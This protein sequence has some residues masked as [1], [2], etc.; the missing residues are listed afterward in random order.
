MNFEINQT[1][2]VENPFNRLTGSE[3][4]KS[5]PLIFM[6][7]FILGLSV[8][9]AGKMGLIATFGLIAVPFVFAYLFLLFKNP[10]IGLYTAFAFGFVLIGLGRYVQGV[11]VGL[12]MD[13]ILFLTLLAFV[14]KNF[15]A[16]NKWQPVKKD[17][18]VLALI[19]FAYYLFEAVNPEAR[20][21]NAWFTGRTVALYMF[22]TIPL[23]LLLIDNKRK[24][25]N[26]FLIWGIFSLLATSKGIMQHFFG[27]D[28][29]ERIWLSEPGNFTTHVLF[30]KLRVFSFL[31]DAGQFGANQGYSAVVA[32][33]YATSQKKFGKKLFFFLVAGMGIYGMMISGT[34]GAISVPAVGFMV[35]IILKKNISVLIPG[36]IIL[37]GLFV[38]FKYT[39]IGQGNAQIARMR[40]AFDPNNASLQVRLENQKKLKAYLATRPFGGGVG[41]AGGKARKFLPNAFLSN[42]PTDSWYVMIWAEMGIVGLVIHLAILFYVVI[43][44]SFMVMFRL[45]DPQLRIQM[46]ALTSGMLGIMAA[47]YG[48]GVLGQMPTGIYIYTSMALMLNAKVF[49]TKKEELNTVTNIETVK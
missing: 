6:L 18:S 47:A 19:W 1:G 23:V 26:F 3:R 46:A 45:R 48:N 42:V 16:K 30:G 17:V 36:F 12:G 28:P 21:I 40:S 11:Q 20:S 33:I 2:T 41:H 4:I 39:Y 15:Y 10:V 43:K 44:S 29:W 13:A 35:Y 25:D 32:F 8:F 49:D 37:V 14:F 22:F 34:R 38:F 5:T 27:V 7:A 31:S 9:V 24:L